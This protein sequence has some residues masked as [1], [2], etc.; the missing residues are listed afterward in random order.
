[1]VLRKAPPPGIVVPPPGTGPSHPRSATTPTS[2]SPQSSPKRLTRP[3]RSRTVSTSPRQ[4]SVY[5]PD[6]NTSPAFDLMSPEEAQQKSPLGSSF[7]DSQNP[8]AEELV[9]RPD[10]SHLPPNLQTGA[11]S[12]PQEDTRE[13]SKAG[14]SRVPPIL[15]EGTARRQAAEELQRNQGNQDS[16]AEAQHETGKQRLL[17]NNPFLRARN[18]SSNPWDQQN[19]SHPGQPQGVPEQ[20]SWAANDDPFGER[21][22][23]S[24]SILSLS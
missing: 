24:R 12:Q 10:P 9:E 16:G 15:M 4:V 21:I 7:N 13:E 20:N 1:M 2:N 17:S 8:W 19:G 6:L 11:V 3:G 23:Q 14:I 22:S 18:P 5:S